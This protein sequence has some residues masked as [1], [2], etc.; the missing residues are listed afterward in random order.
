MNTE[1]KTHWKKNNDSRYISGEDLK[2][3]LNGL[4]KEMVVIVASF[5]DSETFDQKTQKEIIKT[6]LYLKDMANKPLYK[7]VILNNTNAK[8]FIKE[9]GSEFMED[10]L[11]KPVTIY[12][13][14]DKRHGFVVRFKSYQKPVLQIGTE[15]FNKCVAA[16]KSKAATM[17]AVKV[18]Y[19]V[20]NE[21]EA[22]LNEEVGNG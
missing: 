3:E 15:N 6:G 10:W 1:T 21:V 20:S 5:T 9:T 12:A 17:E 22:K 13:C 7:P 18:R 11:N 4:K 19:N 14:P 2:A 8:F 16:L